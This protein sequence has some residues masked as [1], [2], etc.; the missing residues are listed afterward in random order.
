MGSVTATRNREAHISNPIPVTDPSLGRKRLLAAIAFAVVAASVIAVARDVLTIDRLRA[1][2]LWLVDVVQRHYVIAVVA[3][4][5]AYA[6]LCACAV[7]GIVLL[8]IAGGFVFSPIPATAFIAVGATAGAVALYLIV[9]FTA[10]DWVHAR[11]GP[12]AGRL[13]DGFRRN[14]W[15]YLL[16]LRL[17]PLFPFV[18]VNLTAAFLRVPF[19]IYVIGTFFGLM[20]GTFVYATLGA[21]IG[22]V[23]A[24]GGTLDLRGALMQPNVIG[25]LGGLAVLA[26]LPLL[27][28]RWANVS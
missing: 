13:E 5:C 23:L 1:E 10:T 9:R 15:S 17:V 28:K 14:A 12:W 18:V 16:I 2:Q 22:D 19:R 6:V 4:V 8:T 3:F 25:S 21:G 7:P 26:I 27:Y 11:V 24:A 20:P